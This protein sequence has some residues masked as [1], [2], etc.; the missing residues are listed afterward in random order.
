[1]CSDVKENLDQRPIISLGPFSRRPGAYVGFSFVSFF[2]DDVVH[3]CPA[4]DELLVADDLLAEYKA[5][6]YVIEREEKPGAGTSANVSS[7]DTEPT[8]LYPNPF[9]DQLVVESKMP[10]NKVSIYNSVGQ[11]VIEI[12]TGKLLENSINT[13]SLGVGFYFVR[14]NGQDRLHKLIKVE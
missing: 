3:P 12:S 13:S 6:C 2:I 8:Y 9:D 7:A 1:M 5:N 11:L 4:L 14:I 10:L